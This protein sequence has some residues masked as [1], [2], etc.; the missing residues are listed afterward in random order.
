MDDLRF[1]FRQ[2]A[3]IFLLSETSGLALVHKQPPVRWVPG[4]FLKVKLEVD[5]APLYSAKVRND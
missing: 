3:G 2:G 1:E 5:D 4:F